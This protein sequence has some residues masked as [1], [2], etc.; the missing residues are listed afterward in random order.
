MTRARATKTAKIL[1][2]D[3]KKF[4]NIIRENKSEFAI[5]SYLAN[6][7]FKRYINTI[8]EFEEYIEMTR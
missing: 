8:K 2:V 1:V 5:M 3:A 7:Y 6:V 4:L